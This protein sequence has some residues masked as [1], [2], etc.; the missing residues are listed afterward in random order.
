MFFFSEEWLLTACVTLESDC[1][2]I[3]R[4]LSSVWR[5]GPT[6]FSTP[7]ASLCSCRE[8]HQPLATLGTV[9]SLHYSDHPHSYP[10]PWTPEFNKSFWL[11]EVLHA[12]WGLY[13]DPDLEEEASSKISLSTWTVD[14]HCRVWS[15]A[16]ACGPGFFPLWHSQ[17]QGQRVEG[18][19]LLLHPIILTMKFSEREEFWERE[20]L[21][22][23]ATSLW[24]LAVVCQEHTVIISECPQGL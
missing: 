15:L 10:G 3:H 4:L 21:T 5:P 17:S 12:P 20:S 22:G 19:G 13:N 7:S 6:W 16:S 8:T 18:P 14:T 24:F 23:T 2:G 9:L 11:C 1:I